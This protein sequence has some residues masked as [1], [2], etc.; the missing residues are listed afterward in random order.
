MDNVWTMDGQWMDNGWTMD[1]QHRRKTT[2]CR[3]NSNKYGQNAI[4]KKR[5]FKTA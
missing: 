3:T 4:E 5:F 2:T 1:G